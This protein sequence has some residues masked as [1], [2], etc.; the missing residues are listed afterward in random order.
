MAVTC[1]LKA[2]RIRK[3]NKQ[4]QRDTDAQYV[5][6]RLEDRDR[7]TQTDKETERLRKTM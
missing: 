6:Y 1:L 2:I 5:R 4:R 3:T 7:V